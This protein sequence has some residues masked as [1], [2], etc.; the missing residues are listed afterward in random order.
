M[1]LLALAGSDGGRTGRGKGTFGWSSGEPEIGN[2]YS[3]IH[4]YRQKILFSDPTFLEGFDLK[5]HMPGNFPPWDV[6]FT[7]HPGHFASLHKNRPKLL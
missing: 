1:V 4:M 2:R 5:F 3:Y 6:V 7:Y